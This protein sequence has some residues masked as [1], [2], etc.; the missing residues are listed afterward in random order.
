MAESKV[1]DLLYSVLK[2]GIINGDK[3][4]KTF[5]DSVDSRFHVKIL[6]H[7]SAENF[8][9]FLRHLTEGI[10]YHRKYGCLKLFAQLYKEV[11]EHAEE[12]RSDKYVKKRW[13]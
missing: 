10:T 5:F 9:N 7:T 1:S 2:D 12:L 3:I 13:R 4:D 8:E 11:K 6:Q